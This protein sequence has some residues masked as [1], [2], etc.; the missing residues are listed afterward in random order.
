MIIELIFIQAKAWTDLIDDMFQTKSI[1]TILLLGGVIII[2][3]IINRNK[4]KQKLANKIHQNNAEKDLT[5]QKGNRTKMPL[6]ELLKTCKKL[7]QE[8]NTKKSLQNLL[9]NLEEMAESNNKFQKYYEEA[10]MLSNRIRR[11]EYN[12]RNS[13]EQPEG[14]GI[15]NNSINRAILDIL[16]ELSKTERLYG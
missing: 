13:L 16:D 7:I 2:L 15:Q 3:A 5:D 4:E 10:L 11:L 8:G 14:L 9:L 12:Q 6:E 1:T